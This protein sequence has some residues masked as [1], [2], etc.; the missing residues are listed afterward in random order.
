MHRQ[1]RDVIM[2]NFID[3]QMKV[4]DT[5]TPQVIIIGAGGH[6]RVIADI[7]EK[8]GHMVLGFLDDNT[9]ASP[10]PHK[11]LGTIQDVKNYKQQASFILGIGHNPT[12]K[13]LAEA[14]EALNVSWYTAVHPNAVIANTATIGEGTVVMAQAVI[15]P[16]SKVSKHCII[17]TAAVVEHDN[18]ICNYVHISPN[19]ATGGN[20]TVGVLTHVGIGATIK[21]NINIASETIIGAGAVVVKDIIVPGV[22]IGIPAT[23]KEVNAGNGEEKIYLNVIECSHTSSK[24]K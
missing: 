21:N 10:H 1:G 3:A 20:V 23:K 14:L 13:K 4:H 9:L 15:N 5:R 6:G 12:R 17:N 8:C 2:K 19:A 24:S 11:L 7:V 16:G 22:Y 18:T